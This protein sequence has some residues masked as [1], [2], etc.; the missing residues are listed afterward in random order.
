M[1]RSSGRQ[2]DSRVIRWLDACTMSDVRCVMCGCSMIQVDLDEKKEIDPQRAQS[3][4]VVGSIYD[5]SGN[6]QGIQARAHLGRRGGHESGN[7]G[8]SVVLHVD[9]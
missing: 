1:E 4:A 6:G 2:S 7:N 9:K 5:S 3:P 8:E